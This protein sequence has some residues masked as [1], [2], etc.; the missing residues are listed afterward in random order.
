MIVMLAKAAIAAIGLGAALF[1]IGKIVLGLSLAF[2]AIRVAVT[3]LA[4]VVGIFTGI[5]KAIMF[6][7][8]LGKFAVGAFQAI[9]AAILA[10]A[11]SG[12]LLATGIGILV[13]GAVAAILYLSGAFTEMG[14]VFKQVIGGIGDALAA[15]DIALAAQILWAGLRVLWTAGI[16]WIV[17]LWDDL[18][19]ATA[20]AMTWLGGEVSKD[21]HW[22]CGVMEMGWIVMVGGLQAAWTMFSAWLQRQW[23]KVRGLFDSKVTVEAEIARINT[24]RDQKLAEIGGIAQNRWRATEDKMAADRKGRSDEIGGLQASNDRNHA[25]REAET[26][27]RRKEL[28]DLVAIAKAKKAA[29]ATAATDAHGQP[30][31]GPDVAGGAA[32]DVTGAFDMGAILSLSA[33]D[34]ASSYQNK[35]LGY[36]QQIAENTASGGG[37]DDASEGYQ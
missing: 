37:V 29:Q 31:A 34:A 22:L 2:A 19:T 23:A 17:G 6:L 16:N 12:A 15:G 7:G 36:T 14:R 25:A 32:G 20:Q 24:E 27:A 33:G 5:G 21:W 30:V 8:T 28:A 11:A 13:V 9:R 4:F 26:E 18:T 10:A 35:M 3:T 1:A